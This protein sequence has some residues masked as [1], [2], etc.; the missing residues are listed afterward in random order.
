MDYIFFDFNG[1]LIDDVDLC[2]N[3]LNI[4]LEKCKHNRIT[5]EQYLEIFTFPVKEYYKKAGFDFEVDDWD[6]L[7]T[8]FIEE[9]K[10]NNNNCPLFSDIKE[11][12]DLLKSQGKHLYILSASERNMLI[13]QLEYYEIKDYFDEI[14]GKDNIYAEGKEKIGIEF[15]KRNKL[16][17][18]KCVFVGDTIHDAETGDAMGI[19]SYLIARG[20]QNKNRLLNSKKKV[21]DSLKEI[22]FT[23]E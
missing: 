9:Y 21:F 6:E 13:D 14:L 17:K 11:T 8:F 20:H 5:K 15:M 4:M 10:K 2:F 18:D 22:D 12:L 7:A 19:K 3:L 16:P 1:T 23:K